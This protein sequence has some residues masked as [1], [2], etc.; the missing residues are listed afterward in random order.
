MVIKCPKCAERFEIEP[1]WLNQR[2]VC[3]ICQSVVLFSNREARPAARPG[4]VILDEFRLHAAWWIAGGLALL[5]VMG[6]A[7]MLRVFRERNE[8]RWS[9]IASQS[10]HVRN[11]IDFEKHRAKKHIDS[12]PDGQRDAFYGRGGTSADRTNLYQNLMNSDNLDGAI[13]LLEQ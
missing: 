11:D 1:S 9:G 13:R 10:Y 12:L 4:S 5:F 2:G 8:R 3:P 7:I 6:G